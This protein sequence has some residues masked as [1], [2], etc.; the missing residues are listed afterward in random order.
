DAMGVLSDGTIIG[1]HTRFG[2]TN[3]VD[4][5]LI[6]PTT[7]TATVPTTSTITLNGSWG[8]GM[9]ALDEA[10]NRY[11]L[12]S[13]TSGENATLYTLELSSGNLL[14]T[15]NLTGDAPQRID[16]IEVLADGSLLGIDQGIG[17]FDSY[18]INPT[19][20]VATAYAN[21]SFNAV[22]GWAENMFAVNNADG[23][24]YLMTDPSGSGP[25]AWFTQDLS[26]GSQSASGT[27]SGADAPIR[28]DA[29][30]LADPIPEPSALL[31]ALL[32][33]LGLLKRRRS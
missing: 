4:T 16:S 3:F 17:S 2:G 19:T 22:G 30:G 9:F 10:N 31:A 33:S 13:S 12:M 29:F 5:Y 28:I 7:G 18:L 24:F 1:V 32:G 26:D 14:N 15:A 27:L 21:P 6:N 20:A 8:D 23:E 11:Y 25:A